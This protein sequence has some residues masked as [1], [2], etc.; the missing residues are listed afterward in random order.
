MVCAFG[1][2]I[3][4]SSPRTAFRKVDFPA[5]GRPSIVM[6][7]DLNIEVKGKLKDTSD[8]IFGNFEE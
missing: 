5:F 4:R 8:F 2:V 6:N 7:A 3:T 1:F